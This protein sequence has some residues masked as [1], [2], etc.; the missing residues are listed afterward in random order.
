ML[1]AIKT[2]AAIS[3]ASGAGGIG[4][5]RISGPLALELAQKISGGNLKPRIANFHSFKDLNG[6][7]VDQGLILF[8]PLIFIKSKFLFLIIL[9]GSFKYLKSSSVWSL[10]FFAFI[11]VCPFMF[12]AA[13]ITELLHWA[14][15]FVSE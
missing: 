5:I 3:T 1:N 15:P 2:I 13:N 7:L 14:E 8:F 4:V 12:N 9:I 11:T 6:S 10:D